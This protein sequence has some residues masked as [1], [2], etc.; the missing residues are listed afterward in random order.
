MPCN[1]CGASIHEGLQICPHCGSRQ[2]RRPTQVTCTHC[3][4]HAPSGSS[5]CPRCGQV[6]RARRLP[7]LL[8]PIAAGL[9]LAAIVLVVRN[10]GD[11]LA[12]VQ[13]A[14]QQKLAAAEEHLNNLG[15]KVLDTASSLADNTVPMETPT[16]TQVVVMVEPSAQDQAVLVALAQETPA[17]EVV[18][19]PTT[20]G[21]TTN[22]VT[23]TLPVTAQAVAL[24]DIE[25]TATLETVSSPEALTQELP[26]PTEAP[27]QPPVPTPS[28]TTKVAAAAP[29]RI[30]A[31]TDTPAPPTPTSTSTALPP[32][33]TPT[34]LPPTATPTALPPTP[35]ST[36]LPPTATPVPPTPTP[37]AKTGTGGAEES[38]YT[39][40]SG[41]NWYSI[42]KR[43]GITQEELAAA[44]GTTPSD[45]LQVDQKLRIPLANSE[46]T[47][48]NQ[49]NSKALSA[50]T[51]A[52]AVSIPQSY[53]VQRGDNWFSIAKRFGITQEFLAAYNGQ[54]PS[55]VLQVNQKLR[56]PAPGATVP[57]PTATAVVKPSPTATPEPTLVPEAP[58]VANLSAPVLVSPMNGDG[59]S[60]GSLPVLTW[61]PVPGVTA[62]DHYYVRV[63]F[64]MRNGEPGLVE[65]QVNNLSF[66]LPQWVFES[67]LPPDR[68]GRWSV[69]VRRQGSSGEA[70][71]I[72]PS[73]ETRTFYWR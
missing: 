47:A 52:T 10:P 24:A 20:V 32:T 71:E 35:T 70:N 54:T 13:L 9:L 16:P 65:G 14:T 37:Q 6:L 46:Q 36:V 7:R 28:P 18:V 61:Q 44:N 66:T 12:K 1:R 17:A 73:S 51:Q 34:A 57:K 29:K 33:A 53:T 21:S 41:D 22:A 3:R 8:I 48:S 38:S 62:D 40:E 42:A 19:A 64:T 2:K 68:I 23:V 39:V 30:V 45:I 59:F 58:V 72:S 63:S 25:P 69:Q 11:G 31:P 5:V 55:D 50:T 43:Y 60:S 67:A 49:P 15:G 27:T 56:I 4:Y 26:P